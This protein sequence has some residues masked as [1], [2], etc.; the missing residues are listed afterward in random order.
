MRFEAGSAEQIPLDDASVDA[1][2]CF[3]TLEHVAAHD[4]V[5]AEFRRVLKPGG[6][7]V[8][9][10]PDRLEYSEVPKFK[11][12]FHVRELYLNEFRDLLG[13]HFRNVQ[14]YGQRV[15]YSSM[16]A[17]LDDVQSPFISF[18]SDGSE[19]VRGQGIVRPVYFLAVASDRSCPPLPA[20][21]LAPQVPGYWAEMETLR[22]ALTSAEA[23]AR[24]RAGERGTT[25]A[26]VRR[27]LGDSGLG[28]PN[29]THGSGL[30]PWS[31]SG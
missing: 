31:S 11:N 4:Q 29:R 9:S 6:F 24:G 18:R 27:R 16:L 20:G 8:I 22:A 1:V 26:A 21:A 2:V 19:V 28:S 5:L 10:C 30:P 13:R 17:P 7:L 15:Q 12:P 3:D 25:S 14:V 23:I